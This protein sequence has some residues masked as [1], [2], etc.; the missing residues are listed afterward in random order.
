MEWTDDALCKE[1]FADTK[2]DQKETQSKYP[3]HIYANPIEWVN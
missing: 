2:T 1:Y 3:R